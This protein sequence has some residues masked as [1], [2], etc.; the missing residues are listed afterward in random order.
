MKEKYILKYFLNAK[1]YVFFNGEKSIIHPHN[2]QLELNII[3][4]NNEILSYQLIDGYIEDILEQ[5][6]GKVLND[7]SQFMG[8]EATTE[9]LGRV[10]WKII[11][12]KLKSMECYLEILKISEN[13]S[14]TFAIERE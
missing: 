3:L 14:R 10:L 8:K 12:E 2:W 6:D 11:S 1:H 5:F 4:N 13:A 7:H 9:E